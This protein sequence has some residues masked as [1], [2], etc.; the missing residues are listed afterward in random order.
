MVRAVKGILNKLTP[1]NFEKLFK[2]LL[3]LGVDSPE[4]LQKVIQAIF[5]KAVAEPTFCALYA[6]LCLK[7]SRA[8]PEFRAIGNK[9]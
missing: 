6:E 3:E 8:L 2:D 1:E 7:L 5:E 9:P 4:K